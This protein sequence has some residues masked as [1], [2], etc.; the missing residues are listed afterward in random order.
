MRMLGD[1]LNGMAR[2]RIGLNICEGRIT[3]APVARAHGP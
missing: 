3:C 1:R 2:M